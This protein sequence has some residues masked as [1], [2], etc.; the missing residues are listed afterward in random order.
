MFQNVLAFMDE[1]FHKTGKGYRE[2]A[3]FKDQPDQQRFNPP[4]TGLIENHR[5]TPPKLRSAGQR[6]MQRNQKLW[7]QTDIVQKTIE[8]LF[9]LRGPSSQRQTSSQGC[10]RKPPISSPSPMKQD[11]QCIS[12]QSNILED[13]YPNHSPINE[14]KLHE[15]AKQIIRFNSFSVRKTA[16]L[17]H[18]PSASI[19]KV[20]GAERERP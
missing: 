4:N 9:S 8:S 7:G 2:H 20:L 6:N 5:Q 15:L 10:F 14:Q 18:R 16:S 1:T 17:P 11:D 12:H 19:S 3:P 13:R